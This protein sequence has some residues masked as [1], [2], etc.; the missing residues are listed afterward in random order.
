[1][2]RFILIHFQ[3]DLEEFQAF[4]EKEV[5]FCTWSL[6]EESMNFFF[7]F[8]ELIFKCFSKSGPRSLF[9]NNLVLALSESSKLVLISYRGIVVHEKRCLYSQTISEF[10][11]QGNKGLDTTWNNQFRPFEDVHICYI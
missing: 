4:I 10:L 8:Y 9:L 2:I 5:M 7:V 11:L 6:H 3:R 1:M